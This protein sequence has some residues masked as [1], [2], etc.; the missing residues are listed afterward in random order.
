MSK[1]VL[2]NK[3]ISDNGI[4]SKNI[5]DYL[6]SNGFIANSPY[7]FSNVSQFYDLSFRI[8][9]GMASVK[10]EFKPN[11]INVKYVIFPYQRVLAINLVFVKRLV[12]ES[13]LLAVYELSKKPIG[14]CL[15]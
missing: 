6:L 7:S 13:V 9:Y 11:T 14:I 5:S 10:I 4:C 1:K 12:K 2:I 3:K 15:V 8:H